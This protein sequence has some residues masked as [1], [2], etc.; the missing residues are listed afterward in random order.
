[1]G[2]FASGQYGF[3]GPT[4]PDNTAPVAGLFYG[5]GFGVLKAQAIGSFTITLAVFVV[6]FVMMFIINKL[7]NPWKLRIEEEGETGAGGIDVFDH[8]IEVYPAQDDEISLSGLF[9][10]GVTSPSAV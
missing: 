1:L 10:K 9:D 7:P 2:L 3:T 6:T 4:G 5:G 8:G